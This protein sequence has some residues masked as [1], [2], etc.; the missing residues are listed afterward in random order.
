M[1]G[2]DGF[3]V[4]VEQ[5]TPAW[6]AAL[7]ARQVG[8]QQEGFKEPVGVG[9][10]PFG[11]TGILHALESQILWLQ[12]INQRFTAPSHLQQGVQQQGAVVAPRTLVVMSTG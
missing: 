2:T 5:H 4:A 12:W 8:L 3:V 1:T 11:W 9:Q 10:M 6:V 7:M